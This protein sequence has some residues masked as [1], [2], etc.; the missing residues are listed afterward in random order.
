MINNEYSLILHYFYSLMLFVVLV[1]LG[2][3][4]IRTLIDDWIIRLLI[5][6]LA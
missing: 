5:Q 6:W 3:C 1:V 2:Y 4:M